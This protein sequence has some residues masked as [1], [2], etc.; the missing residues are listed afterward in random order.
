MYCRVS[1]RGVA[2]PPPPPTALLC[3][4]PLLGVWLHSSQRTG[5][6][7]AG[8]QRCSAGSAPAPSVAAR[9]A[10]RC[11]ARRC[12]CAVAWLVAHLLRMRAGAQK[13]AAVRFA[14]R[15]AATWRHVAVRAAAALASFAW[16]SGRAQLRL[17][18]LLQISRI[19]VLLW[20]GFEVKRPIRRSAIPLH[21]ALL[22]SA[23]APP[24]AAGSS[25]SLCS[26]SHTLLLGTAGAILSVHPAHG[27]GSVWFK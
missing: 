10:A 5:T 13:R 4:L 27:Q 18:L 6:Q 23:L 19:A 22:L 21:V 26:R 14:G 1:V 16:R 2:A 17:T 24:G 8:A 3:K 9:C 12:C 20:L 15:A 25:S 7:R 11:A